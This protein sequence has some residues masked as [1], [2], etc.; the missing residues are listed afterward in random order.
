M[1]SC[2]VRRLEAEGFSVYYEG[3]G[4]WERALQS[5]PWHT[6]ALLFAARL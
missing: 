4:N 2:P 5:W 6:D 3:R 1:T